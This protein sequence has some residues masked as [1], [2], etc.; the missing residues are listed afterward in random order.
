MIQLRSRADRELD[1]SHPDVR[2]LLEYVADLERELRCAREYLEACRRA[3][4][5]R[6]GELLLNAIRRSIADRSESP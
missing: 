1:A 4:G 5:A 6:K 3:A 2:Y